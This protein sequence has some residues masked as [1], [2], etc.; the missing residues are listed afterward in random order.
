MKLKK[1][2][3]EKLHTV[4]HKLLPNERKTNCKNSRKGWVVC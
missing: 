3:R 4:G 2:N 1:I